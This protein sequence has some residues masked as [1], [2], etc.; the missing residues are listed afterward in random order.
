[1]RI[2]VIEDDPV[3]ANCVTEILEV[4]G[5]ESELAQTGEDGIYLAET[6]FYQLIILDLGLP[7]MK[8]IE[9]IKEIRNH[10][11]NIPILIL[12][13]HVQLENKIESLNKGA[14]DYMIKPFHRDELMAR[15]YALVRR[16]EGLESQCLYYGQLKI[17]LTHAQVHGPNGLVSLTEKEYRLFEI[18]CRRKGNPVTK[19]AI[20][21][22]LYGGIDEP[23]AKIIDV[24]VCNL[25]KKLAAANQGEDC[26][27]T[28]WGR[29]YA[30]KEKPIKTPEHQEN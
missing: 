29:G 10:Q 14:D 9:V 20:L 1:M 8:G 28:V 22:N 2:L 5:H 24:F 26:I 13:G 7:D 18:L 23:D 16:A 12:S 19:E 27:R 15:I 4:N 6:G 3:L 11:Q 21:D 30:L 17:D 25:R